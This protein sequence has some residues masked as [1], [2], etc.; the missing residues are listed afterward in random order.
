MDR[1]SFCLSAFSA[2]LLAPVARAADA[3]PNKPVRIV[4]PY[5]AGGGPDILARQL[6]PKLGEV[7]GQAIVVEN[8]VGAGGVLAAQYVAQQPADGYTVLMGS[9]SHLIQKVLQPSLKFDP[10]GDFLPVTLIGTS[11]SVLVVAD[12]SPYR[13]V[14]DLVAAALPIPAR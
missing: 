12:N 13:K 10:V 14:E 11:P 6:G 9:N 7:L 1:R 3:Y 8:K 5:A 4:V 2:A